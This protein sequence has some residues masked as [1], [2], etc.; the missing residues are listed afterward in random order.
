MNIKSDMK[1]QATE[2]TFSR[3]MKKLTKLTY[4]PV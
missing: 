2:V 4:K 1:K 3:T